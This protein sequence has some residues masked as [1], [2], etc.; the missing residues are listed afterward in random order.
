MVTVPPPRRRTASRPERD[1]RPEEDDPPAS[2]PHAEADER[3]L[4][5]F[6]QIPIPTR[7]AMLERATLKRE[8]R[9]TE[10]LE[11][12]SERSRD[13][14][15]AFRDF[16]KELGRVAAAIE[17]RSP[18]TVRRL[19]AKEWAIVIGAVGLLAT[20]VAQVFRPPPAFP[21][22]I[23]SAAPSIAPPR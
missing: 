8:D 9:L 20:Q 18:P 5:I 17:K 13:H 14:T 12:H 2:S 19:N 23:P 3:T 1:S 15:E 10:A 16:T 22:A 6:A 11:E 21:V 7:L 4:A